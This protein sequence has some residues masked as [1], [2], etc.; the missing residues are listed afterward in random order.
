MKS[1]EIREIAIDSSTVYYDYLEKNKKGVQT[2]NVSEISYP[3]SRELVLRL[4]LS[5]KIFDTD[6]I[7]IKSLRNNREY[8]V[9]EIK[10]IEYDKDKNVLLIKPA[11]CIKS[12]F[13]DLRNNDLKII[14]D[15]KFLVQRVKS[16]YELNG[17]KIQ[18]P[19]ISSKL[20]N[21]YDKIKYFSETELQPSENQKESIKNIFTNPF[22]YI[23]GAPG[24]GKTQFVLSYAVMH[25]ILNNCKIAILAP[26]NNSI[27]QV[28]RGV[29]KMTDKAG[30]NR[31]NIIRLGVPS[32]NFAEDY[33]EV[34]EE[35]GLQKN[36]EE[37]DKQ[38]S[39]LERIIKYEDIKIQF[40]TLEK[41]LNQFDDLQTYSED[42]NLARSKY[43]DLLAIQKRKEIDIN[44]AKQEL[45][46]FQNKK[47]NELNKL[48]SLNNKIRKVFFAKSTI[49]ETD[50]IKT[51][52][53]IKNKYKE[54][55][56]YKFELSEILNL[57]SEKKDELKNTEY[58]FLKHLETIK[59]LFSK[60]L[61]ISKIIQNTN[62]ESWNDIKVQI[63]EIIQKEKDLNLKDNTNLLGSD[64]LN[65]PLQDLQIELMDKLVTR[66]RLALH[67]TD[68]RLKTIK[69]IACTLDGYI[70][71][72]AESKLNVEHIFLDEA[73]YANIIKALTLF[74]NNVPITFLGDHM[75]LPPVCEINDSE[76]KKDESF[77]N[78]FLWSQS[79]IYIDS[80]FQDNRDF[81]LNQYLLN[82]DLTHNNL[83]KTSLTSTFRFGSLLAEI[84]AKYVYS[85]EFKSSN[86][87][88]E[89]EILYIHAPKVEGRQSWISINEVLVI[90]KVVEELRL[91]GD[92]DFIILTPYKRQ[93]EL[94]GKHL[95]R[96]SKELKIST[97]HGSQGRE[98]ETVIFSVVDTNENWMVG[99]GQT[100]TKGL[101]LVNTAVSRARKR[102]IIVCDK[103]HWLHQKGELV[104][105]LLIGGTEIQK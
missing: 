29:L 14:S 5:A 10:I 56:F 30:I 20:R 105:D 64:Y 32:K 78:I 42:V 92:N 58:I 40:R 102:L 73:G 53:L 7:V 84:L 89:T 101:N 13:V 55:E 75:Q 52:E 88:G 27:E 36:L 74:N 39:I 23:W 91:K 17:S 63:Q 66:E 43:N 34:C 25:Y 65:I 54:V 98:W 85:G 94:L 67:S 79:A 82:K 93:V 99:T 77:I 57:I 26:T 96:E 18:L 70:G 59:S 80:I 37:I 16:W 103:S 81:C 68:E 49:T 19:N 90:Q 8:K 60:N 97:V 41:K 38:I 47:T 2:I 83:V 69:V 86:P 4:R 45:Y 104:T 72:Y 46:D 22:T 71:R 3:D 51:E 100:L 6:A 95:S 35:I 1:E 28:L 11:E 12:E 21:K 61:S 44:Y 9:G 48:N 15:L 31:K 33:P 24:T 62:K 50:V 87:N 76:I